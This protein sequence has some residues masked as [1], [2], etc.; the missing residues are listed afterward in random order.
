MSNGDIKCNYHS[1]F[2]ERIRAICTKLDEREK[3][4]NYRF[5]AQREAL[6]TA[7]VNF[8]RRA[9]GWNNLRQELKDYRSFAASKER[10]DELI[11]EGIRWR[12]DHLEETGIWRD[13]VNKRLTVIETRSVTWTAAIGVF[14]VILNI[15]IHYWNR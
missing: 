14:F 3:Q 6:N 7:S 12:E 9:E 11:T 13:L 10:L 4:V 5:E 8:E 1:G 2:E 15:L